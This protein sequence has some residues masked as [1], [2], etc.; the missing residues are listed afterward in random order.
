MESCMMTCHEHLSRL[1]THWRKRMGISQT[2]AAKRLRISRQYLSCLELGVR[3]NPS[4]A[5][6]SHIFK[7][8]KIDPRKVLWA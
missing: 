6:L 5:T 7:H 2:V 4:M 8:T 1:L 3:K